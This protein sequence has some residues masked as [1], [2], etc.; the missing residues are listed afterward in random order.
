MALRLPL[1]EDIVEAKNYGDFFEVTRLYKYDD[2]SFSGFPFIPKENQKKAD[3]SVGMADGPWHVISRTKFSAGKITKRFGIPLSG[4]RTM[5]FNE[6]PGRSHLFIRFT[7]A[8]PM[9][10]EGFVVYAYDQ[11]GRAM[12]SAAWTN[13]SPESREYAFLGSLANL[14]RVEIEA[15]P[16]TWITF[17]NVWLESLPLSP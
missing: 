15:S 17:K 8:H 2:A 1:S 14:G 3:I 5:K 9:R 7:F 6:Y 4:A 16:Y 10:S 13:G 12:E 11:K